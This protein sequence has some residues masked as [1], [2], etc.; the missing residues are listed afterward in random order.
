MADAGR[1]AWQFVKL[2]RTHDRASF[3]SGVAGLDAFLRTSARQ[4]AEAGVSTTIVAVRSGAA[5]ISGF[6][7]LRMGEVVFEALPPDARRRLP[8]NPVPVVHLAR[9]AVDE[10]ERGKGLGE[11]LLL[12]ALARVMRASAEVPALAIEVFAKD[13]AA[14]R[15]YSKYGFG[16]L[17]DDPHHLYLSIKA[18]R[19]VLGAE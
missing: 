3:R 6:F 18:V 14:A 19:K 15:F 5:P 2:S 16:P 12:E 13:A 8:R 1:D 9:L 4:N 11:L 7:T 10:R 17:A